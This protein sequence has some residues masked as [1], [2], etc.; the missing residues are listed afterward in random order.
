DWRGSYPGR[1][2]LLGEYIDQATMDKEIA[3]ASGYGVDFFQMLWYPVAG[4]A[5]ILH[6]KYL[7]AGVDHFIASP[8]NRRMRFCIE[9]CN[10]A[11]FGITDETQ[12]ANACRTFAKYMKHPSYLH[13]GGKPVIKIH[14][15]AQFL[16]QCGGRSNVGIAEERI[17]CLRRTAQKEGAGEILIGICDDIRAFS[18]KAAGLFDY[19]QTYMN[20]PATEA[21][22]EEYGYEMLIDF[23][24]GE[25]ESH[26]R[27]GPL[28][29]LPY[30][31]AGWNP[32]PWHDPRP[33]FGFPDRARW[34][35]A[36]LDMKAL[37]DKYETLRVPDG[38]KGQ[39]TLNIYCWNEFG[40][41]G[42]VAP[43]AGDGWMK[44]EVIKEIFAAQ[45]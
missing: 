22:D 6:A 37:L 35:K 29:F 28:P 11:P 15:M 20:M 45:E 8:E 31:P 19:M 2:P 9:Y 26:A 13:I 41:G 17:G 12:W 18:K 3:A 23:A 40:E 10:H 38:A 21:K 24:L 44:L 4:N 32:K 42:I 27:S 30:M 7:N 33:S 25:A 39:K 16:D 14:T 1:V 43:T 36:L 5:D 34:T